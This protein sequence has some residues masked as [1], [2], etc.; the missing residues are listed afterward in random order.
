MVT[1]N[2]L[3]LFSRLYNNSPEKFQSYINAICVESGIELDTTVVFKQQQKTKDSILDGIIEQQ[4]FKIIIETKL[5]G[6]EDITQ[7]EN[8][9][10]AFE[11]E[12]KQIFLWIN[13]EPIRNTCY[14][15]IIDRLKKF[16]SERGSDIRF[17]STTFKDVSSCFN[18]ILQEYDIEMKTLIEDYISFCEE[19][20]LI[21]SINSRIRVVPTGNTFDD[22]FI[23][24]IYYHP[25][26]RGYRESKYIGLYRDKAVKAIG[27]TICCVDAS[28]DEQI[29]SISYIKEEYGELSEDMIV[30]LKKVIRGAKEKYGYNL[31][32]GYRFLFVN[33]YVPTEYIKKSK[34]GI[35]G[36]RYINLDEIVGYSKDLTIDMIAVLLM[37]KEW[38]VL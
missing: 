8:H 28:Y 4:S 37:K 19:S 32:E 1:N 26:D 11:K 35:M 33:R 21:D 14:N 7:I 20:N 22:N 18:G 23:S 34:G 31:N 2:T 38:D 36:T 17:A 5:Y 9:W 24:N 6:Q 10:E 25:N 12:D 27:E 15:I 13:K 29:D 3:L 16:N 30:S